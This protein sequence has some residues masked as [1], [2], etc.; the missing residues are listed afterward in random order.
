MRY[1]GPRSFIFLLFLLPGFSQAQS[2]IITHFDF[3]FRCSSGGH[4]GE[5]GGS[6]ETGARLEGTEDTSW[7]VYEAH[8]FP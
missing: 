6:R 3:F 5:K 7:S 2:L 1:L 8:A 4:V